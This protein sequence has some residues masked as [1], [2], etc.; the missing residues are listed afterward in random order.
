MIVSTIDII[1]EHVSVLGSDIE[2]SDLKSYVKLAESLIQDEILGEELFTDIDNHAEDVAYQMVV[3]LCRQV[4]CHRA[5]YEGVPYLD[6]VLTANGFAVISNNNVAP[7]SKD[8]VEKLRRGSLNLSDKFTEVL[9]DY[10]EATVTYHAKWKT[11][12][13]YT[14]YSECLIKTAKELAT[15]SSW[16]GNR[17]EF[18]KDRPEILNLTATRLHPYLSKALIEQLITQQN[19]GALT[20]PNKLILPKIKQVLGCLLIL[21]DGEAEL[22]MGDILTII[23]ED[24][25]NYPAYR[26]SLEY[27]ARIATDYV[28]TVESPIF[29]FGR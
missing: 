22:L 16:Q 9:F 10:L 2:W 8:R 3:D 29:V 14:R 23:D 21:K 6:L 15:V 11:S 13:A 5:I 27:A 7:A 24:L 19:E 26:D 12:L 25:D 18:L 4:I 28:N 20:D 1:K 17:T